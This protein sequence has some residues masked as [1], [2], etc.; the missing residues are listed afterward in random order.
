MPSVNDFE[1]L[2]N[3]RTGDQ[4]ANG[5]LAISWEA[6]M[7]WTARYWC[8]RTGK[9]NN[10]SRATWVAFGRQMTLIWKT[11]FHDENCWI[12]WKQHHGNRF[13]KVD[14]AACL[15]SWVICLNILPTPGN[16]QILSD[17]LHQ[18]LREMTWK[19][20]TSNC[21]H[22][23]YLPP[24][25]RSWISLFLAW[26]AKNGGPQLQIWISLLQWVICGL[27]YQ[28]LNCLGWLLIGM[29]CCDTAVVDNDWTTPAKPCSSHAESFPLNILIH[30]WLS[31]SS[32]QFGKVKGQKLHSTV[33]SESGPSDSGLTQILSAQAIWESFEKR[34]ASADFYES[35]G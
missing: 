28:K 35:S 6:M 31:L 7:G 9:S 32:C 25:W 30:L 11:T 8:A 12:C 2:I 23:Q 10:P 34:M 1:M 27:S 17:G 22:V 20:S 15:S 33:F 3:F 4:N 16:C 21:C 24:N 14:H 18:R 19:N 29:E 13:D 5:N 26:S